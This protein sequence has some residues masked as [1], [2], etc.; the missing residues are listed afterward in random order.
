V[1]ELFKGYTLIEL[2]PQTGRQHQIRVHL[3]A[4]GTPIVGDPLYG[5]GKG[6]YLSAIKPGYKSEGEEKPLLNR[7]ALH[8][9]SLTVDHPTTGE[10]LT[11]TAPLP[12]DMSSVLKYLRKLRSS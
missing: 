3:Q 8:A 11:F 7:T 1:V 9:A 6:F 4:L 12:K 2:M 5:D 10:R